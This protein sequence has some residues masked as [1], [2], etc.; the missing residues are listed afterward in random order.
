MKKV[1]LLSLSALFLLACENKKDEKDDEAMSK[2]SDQEKV[3]S[4][5]EKDQSKDNKSKKKALVVMDS[6]S[7]SKV[8]GNISLKEWDGKVK[9]KAEIEGLKPGKHA[10]HIHEKGDCASDDGKSAGGHWNPTGHDHGEWGEDAFHMGD[11]GN[12]DANEEGVASLEFK[13]DKWCIGCEDETKNIV[14]KSFIIHAGEDDFE[15]QP[16][17]A[18]GARVACGVIEM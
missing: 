18:A 14:G 16:S 3:E 10:I 12:L 5:V 2:G 6:K 8:T 17:G 1:I 9:M 4:K 11:I 15:S 13:T 7:G